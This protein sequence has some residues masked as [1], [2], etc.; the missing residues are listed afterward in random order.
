MGD[1]PSHNDILRRLDDVARTIEAQETWREDFR[2]ETKRSVGQLI[3]AV[4]AISETVESCEDRVKGIEAKVLAYDQM[5]DRIIGAVM[6]GGLMIAAI[7]W[8]V[9]GR[10]ESFFGVGR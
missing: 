9:K 6:A 2:A 5:K 10:L 7:W 3:N 1:T 8:L 4:A